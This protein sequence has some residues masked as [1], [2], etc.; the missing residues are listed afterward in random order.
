[1]RSL[2]SVR[3][4]HMC[5]GTHGVQRTSSDSLK[6]KLQK[7]LNWCEYWDLNSGP[8]EKQQELL[9]TESSL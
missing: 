3:G 9:A 1:M 4:H 8:L 5:L 2:Y 6:L 7:S